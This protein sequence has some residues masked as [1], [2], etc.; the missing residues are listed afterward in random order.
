MFVGNLSF[1]TTKEELTELVSTV[2]QP[3]D[4]FLPLDRAT[5]KPRGFAFV[6]F[7]SEDEAKRAIA[8]LDGKELGGRALKANSADERP[9]RPMDGPP[10]GGRPVPGP[11]MFDPNDGRLSRPKGSRRNVRARKRSL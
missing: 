2:G 5:N 4:V 8:M 11:A 1:K 10:R 7:S 9:R 6:E 3:V